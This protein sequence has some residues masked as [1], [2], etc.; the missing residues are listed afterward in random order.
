MLKD[1]CGR[2]R[3]DRRRFAIDATPDRYFV[4]VER[5]SATR[6]SNGYIY[7][8]HR[9][10]LCSTRGG[11]GRPNCQALISVRGRRGDVRKRFIAAFPAS[12]IGGWEM[13]SRLGPIIRKKF[14]SS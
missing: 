14:G 13:K 12:A 1:S 9:V 11:P 7:R 4:T 6:D 3:T 2:P 5:S 10:P 8:D